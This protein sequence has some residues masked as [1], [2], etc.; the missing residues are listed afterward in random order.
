M[1]YSPLQVGIGK[2]KKSHC[3]NHNR[4]VRECMGKDKMSNILSNNTLICI[5]KETPV[6]TNIVQSFIA[7]YHN[8]L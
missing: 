5:M 8:L 3:K 2:Y 1:F 6:E 4:I 7:L